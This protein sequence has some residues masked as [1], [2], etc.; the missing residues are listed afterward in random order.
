MLAGL[1]ACVYGTEIRDIR[2][3][4][5]CTMG[6]RK[7]A[8]A[9]VQHY[10][11]CICVGVGDKDR[12]QYAQHNAQHLRHTTRTMDCMVYALQ[13]SHATTTNGIM[14]IVQRP[15]I[16]R[17]GGQWRPCVLACVVDARI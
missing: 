3:M 5:A 6:A 14:R 9:G 17:G 16:C 2:T 1:Y 4:N 15:L 12:A 13:H 11:L 10:Y 8:A 7:A